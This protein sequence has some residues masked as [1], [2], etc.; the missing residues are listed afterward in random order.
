[1]TILK[2]VV[3]EMR[4]LWGQAFF[5]ASAAVRFSARMTI[6]AGIGTA[7]GFVLTL[8]LLARAVIR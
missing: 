1:M 4:W 2:R 3:A 6:L 8:M 5:G 7:I